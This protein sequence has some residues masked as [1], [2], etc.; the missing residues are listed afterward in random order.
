LKHRPLSNALDLEN[1]FE[2]TA[3]CGAGRRP[4]SGGD[5]L[6]NQLNRWFEKH[7]DPANFI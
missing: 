7:A 3:F 2:V 1:Q 6:R 5:M 4:D